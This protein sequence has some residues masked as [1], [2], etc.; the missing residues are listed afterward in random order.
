MHAPLRR[1]IIGT[2]AV[3]VL[4]CDRTQE[5]VPSRPEPT[6]VSTGSAVVEAGTS[7]AP[8]DAGTH[9]AGARQLTAAERRTIV[10]EL[11]AGRKLAQ[12]K[13]WRDAL[14]RYDRALAVDRGDARVLAEAGWAAFNA[15]D[16]ARA[17]ARGSGCSTLLVARC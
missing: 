10:V 4:G 6:T 2:F 11:T 12:Q 14:A 1:L 7:P 5:A 13:R 3:A 15:G 17:R 9:D 8:R 16:V